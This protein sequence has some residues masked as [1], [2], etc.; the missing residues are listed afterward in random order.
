MLMLGMYNKQHAV[1]EL[2]CGCVFKCGCVGV[3]QGGRCTRQLC[4]RSAGS[5]CAV[6]PTL[7]LGRRSHWVGFISLLPHLLLLLLLPSPPGPSS[8][9]SSSSSFTSFSAAS[10]FFFFLHLLFLFL[11]LRL[12]HPPPPHCCS[13]PPS[14]PPHLLFLFLF[15]CLVSIFNILMTETFRAHGFFFFFFCNPPNSDVD[16]RI[17]SVCIWSFCQRIHKGNLGDDSC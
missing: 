10:S 2:N 11:L 3:F 6:L 9:P 8:P 1:K 14:P 13:P 5:L 15:L 4:G 17:F 12:L 7:R 16:C